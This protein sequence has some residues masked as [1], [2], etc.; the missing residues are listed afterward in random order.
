MAVRSLPS[1]F[2]NRGSG[3]AADLKP[4]LDTIDGDG[5]VLIDRD[6]EPTHGGARVV[7]GAAGRFWSPARNRPIDFD[8]ADDFLDFAEP[9]FAKAVFDLAVRELDGRVELS[10]ETI[11]AGT[12]ARSTRAFGR[13]WA[14]IRLPSGLIRRSWL[15]AIERRALKAAAPTE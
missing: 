1:R 6:E 13:Y 5:F 10:T 11:I 9:G 12:D 14:L 15:A 3:R 8:T 2:R 4:L 7:M